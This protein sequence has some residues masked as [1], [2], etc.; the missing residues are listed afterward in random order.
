MKWPKL[1]TIAKDRTLQVAFMAALL[2]L[3]MGATRPDKP[4]RMSPKQYWSEK[5]LWRGCADV[6]LAGDSRVYVGVSPRIMKEYLPGMRVLN[7][8]FSGTGYS[9]EYLKAVEELLDGSSDKKMIILGITPVSL[10]ASGINRNH[11]FEVRAER[12]FDRYVNLRFA[13]AVDFLEPM[14]FKDALHGMFPRLKDSQRDVEYFRDGWV[15]CTKTP[16]TRKH[17]LRQYRKVLSQ[18]QVDEAVV[19]DVTESVRRWSARGIR[20]YGFRPPTCREMVEVETQLSGFDQEGF[21]EIFER[22]GGEWIVVDQ[23]G[24]R[25]Y[26]GSH[27]QRDAAEQLSRDLAEAIRAPTPPQ[28]SFR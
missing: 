24:Y 26:D 20:V 23:S 2:V 25:S 17:G 15:A 27:L 28:A 7:Y 13:W 1:T 12:R 21:V 4:R 6:V 22:A 3:A 16:E 5:I 9:P 8:G 14:S 18:Y 11:F 19:S 10:T